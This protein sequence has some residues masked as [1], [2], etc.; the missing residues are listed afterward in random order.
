MDRWQQ[1]EWQQSIVACDRKRREDAIEA[2]LRRGASTEIKAG[3]VNDTP[4]LLAA[5]NGS[6]S[7]VR[8][9][10][11]HGCNARATND[12]GEAVLHISAFSADVDFVQLFT[13][14]AVLL[15]MDALGGITPLHAAVTGGD[16]DVNGRSL[17]VVKLLLESGADPNIRDK[18]LKMAPVVEATLHGLYRL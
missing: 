5:K 11:S 14:D 16:V 7:I 3:E 18:T 12:S 10:V 9:L 4:L 2:L 6:V 15:N 1:I 17:E 8:R 13:N